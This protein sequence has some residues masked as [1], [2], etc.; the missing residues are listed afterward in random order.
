[1]VD[2]REIFLNRFIKI[3]KKPATETKRLELLETRVDG[4]KTLLDYQHKLQKGLVK[5]QKD[6]LGDIEN[7]NKRISK[8]EKYVRKR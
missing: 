3:E 6:F 7:L 4:L 2:K 5:L 1:M 8:L